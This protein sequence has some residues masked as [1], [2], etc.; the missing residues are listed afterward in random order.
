[1]LSSLARQISRFRRDQRGNILML[2]AITIVPVLAGAGAAVDYS[3]A[4]NVRSRLQAASDAASVASVAQASPAYMAAGTMSSDGTI[5]V[6]VR[7]ATNIFTGNT[8]NLS[9][10]TLTSMTA[11]VAKTS[12]T[13]SS[14]V[15]FSADV[16]MMFLGLMGR[17]T[18]TVTGTSLAQAS[19]PQY[20]DFYLLLD[21]SPSMGVA[22]TPADVTKMVNHTPDQCAFA[23]HD[24]SNPNSYYNL[25]KSL[26]VTTRIDVLR[27][28]TQDLMDTANST[29]TY[30]NQFRMAI[31]TFGASEATMGLTPI[32]LLTSNLSTAKSDARNIDLMGV[33]TPGPSHTGNTPTG[34]QD[35]NF[36]TIFPQMDTAIVGTSGSGTSSAPAKFLF[37]VSDGV[38]DESNSAC[39]KA[40]SGSARCQSPIDPA[41]C[42]ALKKRV[43]IAV[44]YTTYLA[45][46][47]NPWYMSWI[48]PFNK[49]PYGPSPNS[50]IAANIKA[51]AS[52]GFYFEVSPTDGISDAMNALFKKAVA[53]ARIT[54]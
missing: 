32:T 11:T 25:A 15:R 50:E 28:A 19:M 51:C 6:G 7:D 54:N 4:I 36:T 23:C 31:Y 38:A 16:P 41:L 43:K 18:M 52:P 47:T 20:I 46:P 10:Y 13:V 39:L 8:S 35:T 26:G 17:S 48:D 9:G 12:S 34:D 42:T 53:D 22:A 29:A 30:T 44:L 27:Q 49:G 14:T 3:R 37:F 2:F 45:L 1:M 24:T 5:D 40:K 21:N 33:T